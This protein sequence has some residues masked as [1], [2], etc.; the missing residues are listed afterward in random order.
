MTRSQAEEANFDFAKM[1]VGLK[2]IDD[3]ILKLTTFEKVNPNFGNKTFVLQAI[4][5]HEQETLREIS[6]YF[7]ETSGIYKRAC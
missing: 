3:A 6:N 5:R 2:T 1:R 7:Y 4:D